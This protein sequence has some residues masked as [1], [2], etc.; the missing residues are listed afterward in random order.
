M[1]FAAWSGLTLLVVV[2][3]ARP[4]SPDESVLSPPQQVLDKGAGEGPAWDPN[5]GL[6]FSGSGG[7]NRLTRE[8]RLEVF[9]PRAGTNGLLFDAEG[10]LL[11]CEPAQRRVTRTEADGRVVVLADR[12]DAGRFNQPNDLALDSRGRIY[13]S[14]PRYGSRDGME[15]QDENGRKIE[16]VYRI[17]PDG[18]VSRII[19]HEVDRPNGLV[20]TADDRYLWVADN[21]NNTVGG[22]RKLWRFRLRDEGE[23]DPASRTL[24]FDWGTSRGPDGMVLDQAGRLYVAGGLNRPQPPFETADR[25]GGIYVF[26]PGGELLQFVAVPRDEV[27]NCTFGG[28]D[29]RDLYITAGGTLWKARGSTPGRLA[30]P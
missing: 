18:K 8:G 15:I 20:V 30:W 22:A 14:D 26:S 12:F 11:A 9:R 21:N 29:L 24:V 2:L 28:D 5:L 10:R 17:D 27:T 4:A 25:K 1:R 7:I 23:I 13:F 6:L 19:T 16:G 3:D